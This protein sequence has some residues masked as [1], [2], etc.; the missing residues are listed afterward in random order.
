MRKSTLDH[1]RST[2]RARP[3]ALDHPLMHPFQVFVQRAETARFLL[4]FAWTWPIVT[5][6][7]MNSRP[8]SILFLAITHVDPFPHGL[9]EDRAGRSPNQLPF[10][11]FGAV[12]I[13]AD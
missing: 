4:R 6:T 12:A 7:S 1:P 2:T 13:D 10:S 9:L 3:P 5:L 8:T 11:L